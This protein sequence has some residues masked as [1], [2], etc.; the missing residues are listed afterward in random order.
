MAGQARPTRASTR[1]A[2][3]VTASAWAVTRSGPTVAVHSATRS[4]PRTSGS[5]PPA[6]R[7]AHSRIALR[8]A[9]RLTRGGRAAG[10]AVSTWTG[11]DTGAPL[12]SPVGPA[13]GRCS[14]AAAPDSA[15]ALCAAS[16]TAADPACTGLT[17]GR[18]AHSSTGA[19]RT[20]S[21]G[22]SPS[23]RASSLRWEASFTPASRA[24]AASSNRR[25]ISAT[26]S[27]TRVTPPTAT[28][29]GMAHTAS[30]PYRG[31]WACHRESRRHQAWTSASI[32]GTNPGG[33]PAPSPPRTSSMNQCLSAGCTV[34]SAAAG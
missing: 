9:S 34:H 20:T 19:R 13:A 6:A 28:G 10:S 33:F 3:P 17:R 23:Q 25:R 18:P 2:A 11:T 12:S 8:A 24:A 21:L 32:T 5:T 26:G 1:V 29:P 14:A 16:T 4:V 27:S 7:R 30:A 31:S 22:R 15:S